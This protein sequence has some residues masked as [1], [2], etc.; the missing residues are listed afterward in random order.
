MSALDG[1]L[2]PVSEQGAAVEALGRGAGLVTA[3]AEQLGARDTASPAARAEA[4]GLEL[5]SVRTTYDGLPALVAEAGPALLTVFSADGPPR[6]L[7]LLRPAGLGRRVAVLGADG[8]R[9][10]VA[11]DTVVAALRAGIE[12]AESPRVEAALDLAALPPGRARDRARAGLLA[13]RLRGRPMGGGALVRAAPHGAPL[14]QARDAGVL[15]PL[16]LAVLA[17]LAATGLALGGWALIGQGALEGRLSPGWLGGWALLLLT[18]L[19]FGRLVALA[20]G[21]AAIRAGVWTK[22]ALLR[23]AMKSDPEQWRREGAGGALARVGESQA[24][25]DLVLTGGIEAL[26]AV[27][28]LAAAV[29]VLAQGTAGLPLAASLV[30]GLLA[31]ALAAWRMVQLRGRWTARRRGLTALLVERMAG[32]RTRLAQ[33]EPGRLYAGEDEALQAYLAAVQPLDRLRVATGALLGGGWTVL[34]LSLLAIPFVAQGGGG[35]GMAVAVGG[36]L[37]GQAALAGVGARLDG[38]ASAAVSWREV[39]PLLRAAR[40]APAPARVAPPSAPATEGEL[41]RAQD[42]RV[43]WPGRPAVL[44]E[45]ALQL[46]VGDRVL[47]T[48]PSGGGKSTLAGVLTGARAPRDGLLLLRGLDQASLGPRQW[49]RMVAQAPQFHENH[50]FENTLAFNLLMA[51]GWPASAAQLSEAEALCREL[52]LG[53]LL[54][55]MPAGLNQIVGESGWQLSHGERSRVFLARALLQGAEVVVLDESFAALD[56]HSLKRCLD[57][58]LQRA[59]TLVVIAHP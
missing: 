50:I 18:G 40:E 53:P 36:I 19:A 42:L 26:L 4:L 23:G 51:Q 25:E 49:R 3:S 15:P 37:L 8:V 35:V 59:R 48:G 46:S 6:F 44:S 45:V 10:R 9:R 24:I 30:L 27:V 7:A 32:H 38:L 11:V 12:Q 31:T 47:V 22:Q 5:H 2:W 39:G 56:P 13:R 57:V 16:V 28:D 1:L 14:A 29:W 54:D 41:L 43:G 21:E 20:Q 52:G 33:A 55:R 34:A 17:R 58:T